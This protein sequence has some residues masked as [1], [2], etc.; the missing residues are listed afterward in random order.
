LLDFI[1]LPVVVCAVRRVMQGELL[2]APARVATPA[3]CG[4]SAECFPRF[5]TALPHRACNRGF[6]GPVR[7]DLTSLPWLV[8]NVRKDGSRMRRRLQKFLPI[9]LIALAVQILAPIAACWATGFAASD[10]LQSAAICHDAA[11]SGQAPDGQTGNPAHDGACAICCVLQAAAVLDTPKSAAVSIV[12]HRDERRIAW[13]DAA[14]HLP[15]SRASSDSK[16]RA[17]PHLT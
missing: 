1:Q 12:L 6:A 3:G 15:P 4:Y 8:A 11:A 17:P 13:V 10:P 7:L 9:V 5:A 14:T 2:P 16:A